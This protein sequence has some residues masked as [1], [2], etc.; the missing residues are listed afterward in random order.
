MARA[1]LEEVSG[2]QRFVKEGTG[3]FLKKEPKNVC[4]EG[5]RSLP[6][7]IAKWQKF[8]LLFSKRRPCFAYVLPIAR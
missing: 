5:V 3:S 2:Y 6:G 4:F 8:L 1:V 7:A